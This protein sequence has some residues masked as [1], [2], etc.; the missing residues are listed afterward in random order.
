MRPINVNNHHRK[1]K[2]TM[3]KLDRMLLATNLVY[4]PGHNM[5]IVQAIMAYI[6]MP[7]TYIE[8]SHEFQ[9]KGTIFLL[10]KI[11]L[12]YTYNKRHPPVVALRCQNSNQI[13][14]SKFKPSQG[15]LVMS[16]CPLF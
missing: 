16:C 12:I 1:F 3:L 15:K 6:Y 11:N 2:G 5:C 9:G 8:I 7:T 14:V 4:F 13:R 10:G